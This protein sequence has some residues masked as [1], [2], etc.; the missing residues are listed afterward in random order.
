MPIEIRDGSGTGYMAK[1]D[2]VNRLHVAAETIAHEENHTIEG[3][4]FNVETPLITLTTGGK[5]GV[6]YLKNNEEVDI[7]IT[8]FFNLLGEVTGVTSGNILLEYEFNTGGGTL[9]AAT[10]NVITPANKRVGSNNTMAATV[11]YGAEGLTVDAGL[12]KISSLS[13]STGINPLLVHITLPKGQSV[14]VSITPFVG[15][16]SMALIAAIDCYVNS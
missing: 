5:S 14:S 1:V 7:I 11:L 12:S 3:L 16:T 10:G 15:T 4:G 8:G 6:L 9:I 2:A 13:T